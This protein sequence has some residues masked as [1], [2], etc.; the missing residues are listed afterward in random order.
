MPVKGRNVH[1]VRAQRH[2]AKRL[3]GETSRGHTDE[4]AKRPVTAVTGYSPGS[5]APG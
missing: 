5:A 3:W 1:Y 2:G 4:G